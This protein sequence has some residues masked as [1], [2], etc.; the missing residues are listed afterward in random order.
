[1]KTNG[2]GYKK[3]HNSCN[4]GSQIIPQDFNTR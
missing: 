2:M 1:M 4:R 3:Y